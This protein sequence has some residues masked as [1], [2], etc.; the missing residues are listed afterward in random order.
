MARRGIKEYK[1]SEALGLILA[2]RDNMDLSCPCCGAKEIERIPKR[3]LR[4]TPGDIYRQVKLRCAECGRS[5]V[6]SPRAVTQPSEPQ[7]S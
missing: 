3:K 2:D 1:A 7:F 6:Y 4:H 5:A